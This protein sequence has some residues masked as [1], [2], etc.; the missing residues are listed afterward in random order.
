MKRSLILACATF[1]CLGASWANP[2][3]SCNEVSLGSTDMSRLKV[4]S[5]LTQM[6]L[7]EKDLTVVPFAAEESKLPFVRT[8][9]ILLSRERSV[10][11]YQLLPREGDRKGILKY[12][13]ASPPN[14]ILLINSLNVSNAQ[15][16]PRGL[17]HIER[18]FQSGIG[19]AQLKFKWLP[20]QPLQNWRDAIRSISTTPTTEITT[21]HTE[22]VSQE[23]IRQT[24]S[25]ELRPS[26]LNLK[27][28]TA[29]VWSMRKPVRSTQTPSRNEPSGKYSMISMDLSYIDDHTDSADAP[30]VDANNSFNFGVKIL[31]LPEEDR[32][33]MKRIN[34]SKIQIPGFKENP[35]PGSFKVLNLTR[36]FLFAEFGQLNNE[37]R[38]LS[39]I[40][41]IDVFAGQIL[42]LKVPQ[43]SQ[44]RFRLKIEG[45]SPINSLRFLEAGQ[46]AD[47][48]AFLS[49]IAYTE[50]LGCKLGQWNGEV[51]LEKDG[52]VSSFERQL[53]IRANI[54]KP[55][56]ADIRSL[57]KPLLERDHY[58]KFRSHKWEDSGNQEV[59]TGPVPS[60]DLQIPLTD[61][62]KP[63]GTPNITNHRQLTNTSDTPSAQ[64]SHP[65]HPPSTVR[66][67]D[68][69]D[70]PVRRMV[71]NEEDKQ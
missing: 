57:L 5:L 34:I 27:L 64:G 41:K 7:G 26:N 29:V 53:E 55:K 4:Y 66:Q 58:F 65:T 6:I 15:N 12:T 44:E 23:T 54:K 52:E 2:P 19:D 28:Q 63:E 31:F 70:A 14:K 36:D 16:M 67:S 47:G 24:P 43:N 30:S 13:I 10:Y 25:E 60:V 37:P 35:I 42:V 18:T 61:P 11:F 68:P 59:L 3:T 71:M 49:Y 32:P 46:A 17:T 45:M 69:Q 39:D 1:V 33:P 9:P 22:T 62:P 21:N 48:S 51:A 20:L 40:L 56:P 38:H 8:E 50:E